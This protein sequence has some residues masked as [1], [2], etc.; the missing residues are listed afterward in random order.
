MASSNSASINNLNIG[1]FDDDYNCNEYRDLCRNQEVLCGKIGLLRAKKYSRKE[2]KLMKILRVVE[3]EIND[4]YEKW[5]INRDNY[6]HQHEEFYDEKFKENT[7]R[8]K[9]KFTKLKFSEKADNRLI[10]SWVKQDVGIELYVSNKTFKNDLVSD[11][12][13]GN[14]KNFRKSSRQ[15]VRQQISKM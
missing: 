8:K 14:L 4:N 13:Q 3:N 1:G 5:S 7:K 10:K 6:L 11:Y 9:G 2:D 12:K 15:Q